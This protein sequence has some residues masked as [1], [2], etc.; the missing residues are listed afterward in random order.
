MPMYLSPIE[1]KLNKF[2]LEDMPLISMYKLLDASEFLMRRLRH[3]TPKDTSHAKNSWLMRVDVQP[4]EMDHY[5]LRTW[6]GWWHG[7]TK[8]DPGTLKNRGYFNLMSQR[9]DVLAYLRSFRLG[10]RPHNFWVYNVAT[11]LDTEKDGYAGNEPYSG[12]FEYME[13]IIM[14][15][16]YRPPNPFHLIAISE[17]KSYMAA[18]GMLR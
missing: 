2:V 3:Y 11:R 7:R 18:R 17:T 9:R 12:D 1:T 15:D 16:Q 8:N 14:G 10:G 6:Q 5:S 4:K 13:K